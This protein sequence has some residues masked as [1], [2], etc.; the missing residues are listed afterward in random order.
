MP[1]R[2]PTKWDIYERFDY[3]PTG[4]RKYPSL[5]REVVTSPNFGR[6]SSRHGVFVRGACS[7]HSALMTACNEEERPR[8]PVTW[9]SDALHKKQSRHFFHRL[10]TPLHVS[11][12]LISLPPP[13]P[14]LYFFLAFPPPLTYSLPLV[15]YFSHNG[16]FRHSLN[17]CY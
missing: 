16:S 12:N 9:L 5:L 17:S 11:T 1:S 3:Q 6:V 2:R 10:L 15:F 14:T 8:A 13:N 7:P 4:G